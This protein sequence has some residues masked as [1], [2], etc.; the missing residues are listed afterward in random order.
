[1]TLTVQDP[2]DLQGAIVYDCRPPLLPVSLRLK[3]IGPLPLRRTVVSAS[4]AAPPQEDFTAIGGMSP[5]RVA[6]PELGVAPLV[7]PDTDLEDELATPEDSMLLSDS[8]PEGVRLPGVRPMPPD[9]ADLELEKALLSVSVLPVMVT[10]LVE[11]VEAFP[12]PEPPVPVLLDDDPGA[13]SRVSP[14]RVAAD[15]LV[16]DVFPSYLILPACSIYEPVT[17]P[18]TPSLQEDAY[19]RPLT[20]PAAM[21]QYL[22]REGD[23]LLGDT[24]DLPLLSM[25]LMPLPV[26]VDVVPES[27]VGSPAGEPVV[28]PSDGMLDLS[29]EGSFDVYQDAL[30]SGATPQVL[31][32]LPG[33]QYRMTSYDDDADL[34]DLNVDIMI[35]CTYLATLPDN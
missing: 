10:P 33:C 27:S 3:D 5:E 11:P 15:G 31:D 21:D 29:Q 25:P 18:I 1:M 30:E 24:A 32:S 7:D 9:L 35:R 6:I 22:S 28:A 17:S 16:L 34:S 26:V 13:T 19:Y 20:S 23:L 2:S 12:Y 8:S 14:L 4:L